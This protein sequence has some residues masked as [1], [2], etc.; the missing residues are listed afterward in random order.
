MSAE[1]NY[2]EH[3][4]LQQIAQRDENAFKAL[5]DLYKDRLFLYING[6]I[7]S[8]EVSEEIVMDVFLKIWLG[9]E[10]VNQ[11]ENFDAFLFRVAYNKSIDFLRSAARDP[12]LRD[13]VWHEMQV[14]GGLNADEQVITREYENKLREAIGLLSP[15]RRLV[16]QMSR[17]KGFSHNA[18]ARQLQLS[19]H[20]VSNHIV[21]S[22]RFIRAYL[23]RHLDIAVLCFSF[24]FGGF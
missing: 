9:K 2:N 23:I 12:K 17:E 22:Q 11:I 6:I 20:T 10:I 1:K 15:Q 5:F 3:L 18:I 19:K 16:Y 24:L 8:K 4:L 14:A 21:E 7:K 13:L